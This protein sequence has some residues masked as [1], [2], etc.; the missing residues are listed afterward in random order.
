MQS[1]KLDLKIHFKIEFI[2]IDL[3]FE[4]GEER[5]DE[6]YDDFESSWD[7]DDVMSDNGHNFGNNYN[8]GE[9]GSLLRKPR[10]V[11]FLF[12]LFIFFIVLIYHLNLGPILGGVDCST[13]V[14]ILITLT[15]NLYDGVR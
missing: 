14:I 8:M 1:K 11:F 5:E 6:N 9:P 13:L 7:H 12:P 4:T 2:E 15:C 3:K 10:Q